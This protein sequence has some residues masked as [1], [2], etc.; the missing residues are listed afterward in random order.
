MIKN[1]TTRFII[2]FVTFTM[3]GGF[4]VWTLRQSTSLQN[5]LFLY[6]REVVRSF[7]ALHQKAQALHIDA[8]THILSKLVPIA[9]E[10]RRRETI[11]LENDVQK[12]FS[13]LG[14]FNAHF[15]AE[16]S[17]AAQIRA[18]RGEWS[19]FLKRRE[20]FLKAAALLHND[21]TAFRKAESDYM[22]AYRTLLHE[23]ATLE[24]L[25]RQLFRGYIE[26]RQS[27]ID[28]ALL[29][30]SVVAAATLILLAFLLFEVNAINHKL[31]SYLQEREE[32][33]HK[34]A[35][36]NEELSHYSE[37][38]ESEVKKRTEEALEHL[39][40][41]PLTKL[42]NRLSFMEYLNKSSHASVAIFNID[43]FRSYNDLFGP[44]VGDKIIQEYAAY[45][46]QTIPYIYQIYHLQGD[47]F[48]VAELD[49]KNAATFLAMIKQA[50]KLAREFHF[51]DANGD[52]VLQASIGVAIDQRRPLVKADMALKHAKH[53]NE[54]LVVYSD[55]LIQP[56]RYLENV[57]MTKEL[58]NAI[59]EE[60]IVPYLQPIADTETKEVY[61]YEVL[62]RLVD[63]E[64]KVHP[65]YHFIPLA[66]QIRLYPDITRIIF[67]KGMELVEKHDL[68]LSINLSADDIHHHPTRNFIID[69]LALSTKSDH[70]TFELLE[71]EETK[72][73]DEIS[74]FIEK[75]KQYGVK[76]AID[77][78][79]S[80]Y[81]NFAK[82]LKLKV[83]YLK[84]DGSFI[85]RIDEDSDAREFVEIIYHLASHYNLKTVAEYVSSES[86]YETVR[87]IGIDYVQGYYI[88]EPRPFEEIQKERRA[89]SRAVTEEVEALNWDEM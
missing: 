67:K 42:P 15:F 63:A 47:E 35:E 76:V 19:H 88:A 77:D 40:K 23:T 20:A 44:K 71:S 38:L 51:T 8:L 21:G 26:K 32:Y 56:H 12:A 54:S 49:R 27:S 59:K 9:R 5:D 24:Q 33:Q 14:H 68:H 37:E 36:V 73:Y 66:K 74:H 18:L 84:I 75:V 65:P 10:E 86:I 89:A 43:R 61:K 31:Q 53:S 69:R 87:A 72:N 83:D 41:N 1:I 22:V 52:F 4:V 79:G 64:G 29:F 13:A 55:N 45:L 2:V 50:A 6:E 11:V 58:A 57:T 16:H 78:F 60:R 82:I 7:R 3:A 81:S 62:A 70:I 28:A 17:L 85:K 34:L 48:A 25:Y 46:R 30:S 80:G 39:K